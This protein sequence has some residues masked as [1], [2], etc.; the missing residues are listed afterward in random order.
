MS[1]AM[2]SDEETRLQLIEDLNILQH[3]Q[4]NE[5][6]E[7]VT[8]L[9]SEFFK[10]PMA[11]ITLVGEKTLWFLTNVGLE[12]LTEGVRKV[13]F[14]QHVVYPEAPDCFVVPDA[15][16][17]ERFK[18][19]PLVTGPLHIRF[20]AASPIYLQDV[21]IGTFCLLDTVPRDDFNREK[22]KKLIELSRNISDLLLEKKLEFV[23]CG[24]SQ[25]TLDILQTLTI[26]I[27]TLLKNMINTQEELRQIHRTLQ[28]T[29]TGKKKKKL[30][31]T[32][33][34]GSLPSNPPVI[35]EIELL[36]QLE[37]KK[38]ELFEQRLFIQSKLQKG[39]SS[40]NNLQRTNKHHHESVISPRNNHNNHHTTTNNTTAPGKS[41]AV[42]LPPHHSF[43][44]GEYLSLQEWFGKLKQLTI[45][46][47]PH[48][49][50]IG[51]NVKWDIKL[52]TSSSSSSNNNGNIMNQYEVN[53]GVLTFLS[54]FLSFLI[55]CQSQK[56]KNIKLTLN[57]FP[58]NDIPT[59]STPTNASRRSSMKSTN[60]SSQSSDT[61]DESI[62]QGNNN[63]SNNKD[64][65][66]TRKVYYSCSEGSREAY[67]L[68]YGKLA[69]EVKGYGKINQQGRGSSSS[70]TSPSSFS[71]GA[72][73]SL[74]SKNKSK[75]N[76]SSVLSFLPPSDTYPLFPEENQFFSICDNFISNSFQIIQGEYHKY[77]N[78]NEEI[79]NFWVACFM[80]EK[81]PM[82]Q[83]NNNNGCGINT[84]NYYSTIMNTNLSSLKEEK[85]N[86]NDGSSSSSSNSKKNK[87]NFLS[88]QFNRFGSFFQSSV[89]H[90]FGSR[91]QQ[92]LP[93][94][95]LSDKIEPVVLVKKPSMLRPEPLSI[96]SHSTGSHDQSDATTSKENSTT[97][98][99]IKATGRSKDT[100]VEE[101][102]TSYQKSVIIDDDIQEV[103][104]HE[105][106]SEETHHQKTD[107]FISA[108]NSPSPDVIST[109][110]S[111][112][113]TPRR[114]GG[115]FFFASN[116]SMN[117]IHISDD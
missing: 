84:N 6:F 104:E 93:M 78:R 73:L 61:G 42:F 117:K 116:K 95:S 81:I 35:N 3:F 48:Y 98:E 56:W 10:C 22:E 80:K 87:R 57:L 44:R 106:S 82:I 13:S 59:T 18:E 43:V 25:M 64:S 88:K 24:S 14:C 115:S 55:I 58:Q 108:F 39:L 68:L 54:T 5:T 4:H 28:S 70:F 71:P 23:D 26:E 109:C 36:T 17:D 92:S 72:A 32:P 40:L 67:H 105:S 90:L 12:S 96:A 38:Q 60:K 41:D 29:V 46:H 69:M 8:L 11:L 31:P 79:T 101:F 114:T 47:L 111:H 99:Q 86:N 19:N 75:D 66:S 65:A 103:E 33:T 74:S 27:V 1:G 51:K 63:C 16:L 30:T 37:T 49:H 50:S 107:M 102:S 113:S 20:Y 45:Q 9:A 85:H 2:P 110:S 100:I 97:K 15:T 34:N 112:H 52:T 83:N 77:Y 53:E 21:K 89:N 76:T 91:S 7:K 94:S 62:H